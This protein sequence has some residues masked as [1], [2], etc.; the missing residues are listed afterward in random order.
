MTAS[1][2]FIRLGCLA[3][4]VVLALLPGG[5]NAQRPPIEAGFLFSEG[6]YIA[7]PYAI[8]QVDDEIQVNG[9]LVLSIPPLQG[10][11]RRFAPPKG[12]DHWL[13]TDLA[14]R[15]SNDNIVMVRDHK[16]T[17]RFDQHTQQQ[18]IL[19]A[20]A[21]W[22]SGS[23]R[24][25]AEATLIGA[26]ANDVDAEPWREWFRSFEPPRDLVSRAEKVLA[27]AEAVV[28]ANQARLDWQRRLES[29]IY[30]L[31]VAAMVVSVFALGHLLSMRPPVGARWNELD[32]ARDGTRP[33]V[34]SLGL[35][36]LMS[37]FDLCWTLRAAGHDSF[38]ELNPIGSDMLS[39]PMGM[40]A[41]KASAILL[42]CL[43]LL[44]LRRYRGAQTAT[45][46]MCLVC[47]LVTFRWLMFESMFLS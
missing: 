6:E 7:P 41:F 36:V 44:T 43:L 32:T 9:R 12:V 46:W 28:R 26:V 45:W 38:R 30:G 34:K 25:I 24:D 13:T 5:A 16:H 47:T 42:S 4:A 11:W 20:L 18:D 27:E 14:T 35:I 17:L 33:M 37:A 31:T 40:S 19:A 8:N 39:T 23:K 3:A 2:H 21:D 22:D 10:P 29:A 1:S 15:L